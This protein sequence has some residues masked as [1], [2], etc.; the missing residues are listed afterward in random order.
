MLAGQVAELTGGQVLP[1]T[2]VREIIELTNLDPVVTHRVQRQPLWLRWRY[3]WLVFGCLQIEWI[4]R[5][6]RGLS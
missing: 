6:W 5:K 1:P 4:V 2:A 3:L